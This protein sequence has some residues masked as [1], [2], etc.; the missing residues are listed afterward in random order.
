LAVSAGHGTPDPGAVGP[1]GTK[2]A[3][4]NFMAARILKNALERRKH[5][6]LM[7]RTGAMALSPIKTDDLKARVDMANRAAVDVYVE[8]HCNSHANPAA[9]GME[10]WYFNRS[11][12]GRALADG[13]QKAI[14]VAGELTSRGIKSAAPGKLFVV[15]HTAMTAILIEL[16]FIS[17]PQEERLLTD[18]PWLTRVCEAAAGAVTSF[19]HGVPV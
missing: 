3:E 15:E 18:V 12:T 16:A 14:V 2:E 7:V 10:T 5:D 11:V 17:N 4:V 19:T 9:H 1:A 8:V 13:V 6:V